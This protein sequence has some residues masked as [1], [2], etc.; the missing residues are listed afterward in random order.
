MLTCPD[1]GLSSWGCRVGRSQY[2]NQ[3]LRLA[4]LCHN[5]PLKQDLPHDSLRYHGFGDTFRLRGG[6]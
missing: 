5:I 3:D 4:F 6:P 1:Q 2:A